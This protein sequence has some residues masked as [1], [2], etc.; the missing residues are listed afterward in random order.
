MRGAAG[1]NGRAPG[2]H[3]PRAHRQAVAAPRR[4]GPCAAAAT[5]RVAALATALATAVTLYATSSPQAVAAFVPL[6]ERAGAVVEQ[7]AVRYAP[8]PDP[9]VRDVQAAM[10]QAWAEVRAQYLDRT[11]NGVDWEAALGPALGATYGAHSADDAWAA[12]DALLALLGDPYT[13]VLRPAALADYEASS[14][15]QVQS[16]GLQLAPGGRAGALPPPHVRRTAAAAKGTRA[17]GSYWLRS[18]E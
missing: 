18:T 6:E 17:A 7:G 10:V 8:S 16:L 4:S 11:F 2:L 1:S 3:R 14:A 5:D 15:G 12:V 9:S 13:R